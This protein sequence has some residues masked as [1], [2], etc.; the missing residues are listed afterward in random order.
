MRFVCKL[1]DPMI[2]GFKELRVKIDPHG[3]TNADVV[4]TAGIRA[5]F[6]AP[7]AIVIVIGSAPAFR[8]N[9]P[10]AGGFAVYAIG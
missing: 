4:R 5:D 2:Y 10:I 8:P 7:A 3:G 9:P 1:A 6:A